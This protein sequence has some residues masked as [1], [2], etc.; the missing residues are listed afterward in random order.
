M[1]SKY[2]KI[3][4]GVPLLLTTLLYGY[5]AAIPLFYLVSLGTSI[6][7][8]DFSVGYAPLVLWASILGFGGMIGLVGL[9]ILL[10]R[11]NYETFG[12]RLLTSIFLVIGMLSAFF[13]G[14]FMWG[15]PSS[16]NILIKLVGFNLFI[17]IGITIV[18]MAKKIFWRK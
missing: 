18:G 13:G 6:F 16:D 10:L 3:I 4:L 8:T 2:K 12:I 14:V 1:W 15:A 17:L 11:D 5:L 7:S 9:W